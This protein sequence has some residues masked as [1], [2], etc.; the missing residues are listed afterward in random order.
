MMDATIGLDGGAGS[1][2]HWR[3]CV[4]Q[5]IKVFWFFFSKKNR[6]LAE[7]LACV[8]GLRIVPS[9]QSLSLRSNHDR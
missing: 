1:Q 4:L 6:L 5:R 2:A 9:A 7:F 8:G 3:L